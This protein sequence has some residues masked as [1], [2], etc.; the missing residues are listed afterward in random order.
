MAT[1]TSSED[2]LLLQDSMTD[3]SPDEI[4]AL[5][6][7]IQALRTELRC[8]T[9]RPAVPECAATLEVFRKNCADAVITAELAKSR[10]ALTVK[11]E[12]CPY[13]EDCLPCL[14]RAFELL[15]DSLR[16]GRL[17]A[18]ELANIRRAFEAAQKR[19]SFDSCS[20]CLIEANRLFASHV[21][22]LRSAGV[23]A[24]DEGELSIQELSEEAV[25]AWI[26]EPLSNIVR[27]KIL[28]SLASE[29]KSFADL[30]KLTGLRGGNL[31]FHLEKLLT[32]GIILQKG[33]RK[34][35]TLTS[36]GHELLLSAAGLMEKIG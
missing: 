4:A 16:T 1:L 26:G 19:C 30:A 22:L 29:P 9:Q 27:V 25:T 2:K 11:A 20:G 14:A 33:E 15:L 18:E 34:E 10:A 12:N 32:S 28:K 21:R 17:P 36:R 8:H 35:Y 6:A 23:Y 24:G 7:E 13:K 31:L 3:I 5:R